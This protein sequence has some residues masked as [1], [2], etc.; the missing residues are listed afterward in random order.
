M[1]KFETKMC[2]LVVQVPNFTYNIFVISV[3]SYYVSTKVIL[4]LMR[5]LLLKE[6]TNLCHVCERLTSE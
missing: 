1:P 5:K 6:L 3:T 4:K 2:S